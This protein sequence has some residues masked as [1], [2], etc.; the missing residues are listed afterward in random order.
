MIVDLDRL[1]QLARAATP[2][3]WRTKDGDPGRAW[4]NDDAGDPYCTVADCRPGGEA[5]AA[6]IA[7]ANPA[8]VLQL[9]ARLRAA[10]AIVRD[11]A[12]KNPVQGIYNGGYEVETCALCG[13]TGEFEDDLHQTGLRIEH[14][15]TCLKRRAVEATK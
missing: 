10:E 7:T 6:F 12:A 1:E 9:L 13:A 4:I 8:F 2:G 3:P 5:N 14:K 11:L 15:P